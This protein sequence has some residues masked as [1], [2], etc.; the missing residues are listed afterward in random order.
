[1]GEDVPSFAVSCSILQTHAHGF[2]CVRWVKQS[3]QSCAGCE[4]LQKEL[5]IN[6]HCSSSLTTPA[7]VDICGYAGHDGQACCL[8][9]LMH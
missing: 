4:R 8:Y 2:L 5:Q 7:P 6:D 3:L 9:V 1:M